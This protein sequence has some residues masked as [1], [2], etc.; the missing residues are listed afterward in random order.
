MHCDIRD[1]PPSRKRKQ[2]PSKSRKKNKPKPYKNYM[3]ENAHTFLEELWDKAVTPVAV[4]EEIIYPI[5]EEE[6]YQKTEYSKSIKFGLKDCRKD[7]DIKLYVI[8]KRG[9][10]D[11]TIERIC[12]PSKIRCQ[13]LFPINDPKTRND[14]I[15]KEI[16]REIFTECIGN[17]MSIWAYIWREH[18]G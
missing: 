1:D 9:L 18:Q 16:T 13:R 5:K 2:D 4:E 17:L 11:F 12:I 6:E 7:A 8:P 15:L 3:D 10:M 14:N